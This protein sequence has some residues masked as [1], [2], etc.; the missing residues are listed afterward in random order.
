MF[1]HYGCEF[2]LN[3]SKI[4]LSFIFACVLELI[5]SPICE[6]YNGKSLTLK[7]RT[8]SALFA[9]IIASL[10]QYVLLNLG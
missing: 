6:K 8:M 3:L 2:I 9:C 10:I 4:V 7:V 5:A 1:K